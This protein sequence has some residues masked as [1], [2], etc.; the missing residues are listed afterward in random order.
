MLTSLILRGF[1]YSGD[2]CPSELKRSGNRE[3]MMSLEL[4]KNA[5]FECNDC[6]IIV[7]LC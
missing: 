6:G 2:S 3:G 1:I 7:A 4:G 5:N